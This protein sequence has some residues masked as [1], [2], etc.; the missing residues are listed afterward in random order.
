[1]KNNQ[2]RINLTLQIL[3]TRKLKI[4]LNQ[5]FENQQLNQIIKCYHVLINVQLLQII[6]KNKVSESDC[7]KNLQSISNGVITVWQ[8]TFAHNPAFK[9]LEDD[10]KSQTNC[11]NQK[12]KKSNN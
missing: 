8:E 9:S 5:L 1:M 10:F 2:K 6:I 7:L 12:M 3:W 4:S 11:I